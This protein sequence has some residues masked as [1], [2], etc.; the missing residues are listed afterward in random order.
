MADYRRSRAAKVDYFYALAALIYLNKMGLNYSGDE[1][2]HQRLVDEAFLL[3]IDID[4]GEAAW[5]FFVVACEATSD[6]RR[7]TV[8]KAA[9]KVESGRQYGNGP[10]LLRLIQAFWNQHD[11]STEQTFN[12]VDNMSAVIGASPF[13]P[14]LA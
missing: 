6:L 2:H 10:R 4:F 13:L 1:V 9:L 5:P 11:L 12:Y 14:V 8:L 3:L 7:K